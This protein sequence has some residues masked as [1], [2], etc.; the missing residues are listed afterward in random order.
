MKKAAKKADVL[1]RLLDEKPTAS[2]KKA[3]K[4][5]RKPSKKHAVSNDTDAQPSTQAPAVNST[6]GPN[7][8]GNCPIIPNPE[9]GDKDPAV[10]QWHRENEPH[11]FK[12]GGRYHLRKGI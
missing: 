10:I 1:S 9:L 11:Q 4:R 12:E 6:R 8:C 5:G 7:R 3:A 2:K